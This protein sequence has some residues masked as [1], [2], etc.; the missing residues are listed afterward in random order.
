MPV[1]IFL[2]VGLRYSRRPQRRKHPLISE[3]NPAH[4][5]PRRIEDGVGDGRDARLDRRFTGSIVRQVGP[6]RIGI[7]VDQHDV[8]GG[9]GVG[10]PERGMEIQSSLVTFSPSNCTSSW[11]ARLNPCIMLPSIVLRSPSGL[12][13]SPQSWPQTRRFTQTWP[14]VRFTSTSAISATTVRPR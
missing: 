10:V 3:R 5:N 4:P 9:R 12:I 6:V 2:L 14:V 7:A 11:S 13:T 8:D 1:P